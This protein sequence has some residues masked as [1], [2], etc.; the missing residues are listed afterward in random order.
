MPV[1][2]CERGVRPHVPGRAGETKCLEM[3]IR[4]SPAADVAKGTEALQMRHPAGQD[5]AGQKQVEILGDVYKRQM[6]RR[7]NMCR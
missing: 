4:D 7:I 5:V 3:C 6:Q 2:G 1:C